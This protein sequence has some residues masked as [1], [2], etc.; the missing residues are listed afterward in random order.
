MESYGY[1]QNTGGVENAYSD[2]AHPAVERGVSHS[3]FAGRNPAFEVRGWNVGYSDS[4]E[5]GGP[6]LSF[7]ESEIVRDTHRKL[8]ASARRRELSAVK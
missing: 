1:A 6:D 3:H 2:G 8:K 7:E 4:A 5:T